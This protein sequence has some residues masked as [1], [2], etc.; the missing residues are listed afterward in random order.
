MKLW[1]ISIVLKLKDRTSG[2]KMESQLRKV[3]V[4]QCKFLEILFSLENRLR[5]LFYCWS[6]SYFMFNFSVLITKN[7]LL[8]IIRGSLLKVFG[9]NA[10]AKNLSKFTRKRLCQ[11]PFIMKNSLWYLCFLFKCFSCAGANNFVYCLK[12]FLIPHIFSI[13][14]NIVLLKWLTIKTWLL[15]VNNRNSRKRGEIW[16]KLAMKTHILRLFLV[17][18]LLALNR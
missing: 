18:L 7:I 3:N 17:F 16:S 13:L 15:K 4:E 10:A 2:F 6:R 12:L 8:I 9:K 5:E 1:V 14:S 11:N